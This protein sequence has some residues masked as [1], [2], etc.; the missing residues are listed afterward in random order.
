MDVLT[1]VLQSV[2]L[3]S[4]VYGRME[5]TAP[6]GMR[7]DMGAQPHPSFI[8]VSRGSCSLEVDGMPGPFMLAGG[9]FVL[10]PQGRTN[11]LRDRPE[12]PAVPF[13]E[14]LAEMGQNQ[15]QC[16]GA[17]P[18]LRFGGGGAQSSIVCGCFSFEDGGATPLIEA[19]PPLIHVKGD[20]GA[21]VR[22]LEATL[23]FIAAEAAS[24][25]PGAETIRSR[26]ADILFVQA[27]RVHIASESESERPSGWLRA[28]TDP[29]IGA[30]LRMIHDRPGAPWTVDSLADSVVMSRSAFAERFR[31]LVGVPPLGYLTRWRMHKGAGLLA[32]GDAT[33]AAIAHAVGYE[34]E[35]S[36]GKVFKRY[37]GT[38]PG[39]Y[40]ATSRGRELAG[41]P[42]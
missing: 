40:R 2:R 13:Q 1:D 28:L 41:A 21:P 29:Q 11:T 20:E 24:P 17:P 12:T 18:V 30:A 34:T 6:W 3:R 7:M 27:I 35:G 5:L 15:S 22:W 23:Q 16:T 25:L 32:R 37:T 19:L 33:V 38:S 26:L 9:D 8:V 10:L 36:F 39:E 14:V 4:Q 42:G 31:A